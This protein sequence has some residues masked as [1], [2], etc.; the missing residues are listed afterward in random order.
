MVCKH[1][2]NLSDAFL[3]CRQDSAVA[4][5]HIKSPVNDDGIDKA[6]SEEERSFVICSGEWVRALFT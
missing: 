2:G 5:D 3:L 6:E 4:G 1:T